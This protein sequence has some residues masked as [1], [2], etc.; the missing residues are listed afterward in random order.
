MDKALTLLLA[1][2]EESIRKVLSITLS[3]SGYRVLTAEDGREALRIFSDQRPPIVLTDI[4]MPGITGVELLR[5]IKSESPNTEVIMISGHGDMDLAIESLKHDATDFITKPIN[6]DALEIALKR[7][8]ERISMREQ[9]RTYTEN[10]EALVEEQSAKLVEAERIAAV[11]RTF[12]GLSSAIWDMAGDMEVGI[13]QFNEM[14]CPV[15]IHNKEYRIVAA[16]QL[17]LERYGDRIGQSSWGIYQGESGR[18]DGCPV[19]K[20]FRSGEGTRSTEIVSY[21]DGVD[22][23]VVVH[24]APIRSQE[25]DIELVLEMSAD[26]DEFRRLREELET[27]QQNYQQ[28]FDEVPCYI[29]VQDR[30]LELTAANRNF[31]DDFDFS[32]GSFCYHAYKH[33]SKPCSDCPVVQTFADGSSHQSEMIVTSKRGERYNLLIS[34]APL[35]DS[36]GAVSQVMEMA[37]NITEIRQLQDHLSSLGLKIGTISHGLKGLLTGLDSGAY[38]IDSGLARDD[39][40]RVKEGWGTVKLM[41]QRIRN[42][43][44]DILYYAKERD[45]RWEIIDVLS[46]AEDIA[47]SMESKAK[48]HGIEFIRDFDTTAGSFEIDASIVRTALVNIVENAIDACLEDQQ[49]AARQVRFAV[50]QTEESVLF[51]IADNG[52]GMDEET[53][54]NLFTLFFSSKGTG[55]TGLGLYISK[56]II[57]QHGGSVDV[58]S[59]KGEGSEFRIALPKAIPEYAKGKG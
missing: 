14:P 42:M 48:S 59:V 57:S 30:K 21:A 5:R 38:E 27:T 56:Q 41:T 18:P 43:A 23:Q 46:F 10:L 39:A 36:T 53:L 50:G 45:L 6:D 17:F 51:S 40:D 28:L 19:T 47:H 49:S 29:T 25:G 1:D 35:R 58:S 2:D 54:E 8:K 26:I 32:E 20:T 3:D 4:K 33:A 16:N 52:I 37:T 44:L 13:K 22:A 55:G 15:A 9:I 31:K 24:T 7:A 34:T 12:E 11:S